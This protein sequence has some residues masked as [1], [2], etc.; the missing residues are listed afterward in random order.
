M[1]DALTVLPLA[2]PLLLALRI[3]GSLPADV[4]MRCR[5]VCPAWRDALAE[6]RVWATV[7][8]TATSGVVARVTPALL[9][10]VAARA[11]GQLERLFVT[12]GRELQPA[13]L[14][15][16]SANRDTLRLLRLESGGRGHY[17]AP[18]FETLLRTAPRQCVVEASMIASFTDAGPM[19]RNEA[20]FWGLRLGWLQ[21]TG[22]GDMLATD[23]ASLASALAAHPS[24]RELGLRY[25][26]LST[27]AALDEVVD[28]AVALRLTKLELFGCSVGAASA[29]ALPRLLHDGDALLEFSL[30]GGQVLDAH[31]AQLLAGALRSNRTLTSL[32]LYSVELWRNM[33]AATTLFGALIGHASLT[34]I[35]LQHNDARHVAAA[36]GALLSA[37]VLAESPLCVLDISANLL[38]DDGLLPLLSALPRSTHL[39]ELWCINET[40]TNS[41]VRAT[42]A[43]A[44]EQLALHRLG[45]L[46]TLQFE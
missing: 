2:L 29:V 15:A 12:Y 28:A 18:A 9:R 34:S 44:S 43:W 8:L 7:D 24:L 39:E 46:R 13:L 38:G 33:D 32:T 35:K 17:S 19:L 21:V 36:A 25:I 5:E 20:P 30:S 40:V 37:L 22:G 4:R 31:A 41:C 45:S 3:W 26:P 42:V 27:F 14:A 10:A 23:V 1:R 11:S 16:V 6:P